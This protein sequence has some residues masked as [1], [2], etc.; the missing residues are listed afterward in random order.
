MRYKSY[1]GHRVGCTR[2]VCPTFLF[3]Y[4]DE[5]QTFIL[6]RSKPFLILMRIFNLVIFFVRKN[7]KVWYNGGGESGNF[8]K[9]DQF[10]CLGCNSPTRVQCL[11]TYSGR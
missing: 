10:M 7:E 8:Q 9:Y 11:N 5:T 2:G 6:Y 4:D 1:S 3:R